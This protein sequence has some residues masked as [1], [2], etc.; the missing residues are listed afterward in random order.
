MIN[1]YLLKYNNYYNRKIKKEQTIQEYENYI[2]A[3]LHNI[4]TFDYADGVNTSHVLQYKGE[5]PDYAIITEEDEYGNE[6]IKSRWYVVESSYIR[7]GKY[8]VSLRR[9]LIADNLDEVLDAPCMVEKGYIN[10]P[11]NDDSIFND[12]GQSYNQIKVDETLLYDESKCPW[13]VGYIATPND[14][15]VETTVTANV[16]LKDNAKPIK[17]LSDIDF[18]NFFDMDETGFNGICKC[19]FDD[20][21]RNNFGGSY[22]AIGA[23]FSNSPTAAQAAFMSYFD[24]KN[25]YGRDDNHVFAYGL[26]GKFN[27]LPEYWK[28][29][30]SKD[31]GPYYQTQS[32]SVINQISNSVNG[33]SFMNTYDIYNKSGK[34]ISDCIT[35]YG[36][37]LTEELNVAPTIEFLNNYFQNRYY[38][39]DER[40]YKVELIFDEH[41]YSSNKV[42]QVY[43]DSIMKNLGEYFEYTTGQ[44]ANTS[45]SFTY[46]YKKV[47]VNIK[48]VL[49]KIET[50][51]PKDRPSLIDVPY[52]MF[53][54][55]YGDIN[56]YESSATKP[57]YVTNK[58]Y[59]II[60]TIRNY[61][62]V[63]S[64]ARR[65]SVAAASCER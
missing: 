30:D 63:R 5:T 16:I 9:D 62:S 12:E 36:K 18:Y 49:L 46:I 65:S 3:S 57:D 33:R 25:Y 39:L 17:Q 56:V 1:L 64:R 21:D 44:I 29:I 51:I 22:L 19:G 28:I 24:Y 15:S 34:E 7:G 23:K 53:C 8:R 42:E 6:A 26:G 59:N 31:H 20:Y 48:E 60:Y 35:K 55:P 10:D 4:Y 43:S 45:I 37:R 50:K 52:C 13:I 58:E 61:C 47:K 27:D 54:M 14:E 40:V 38:L 41:I 32:T 11:L 2:L